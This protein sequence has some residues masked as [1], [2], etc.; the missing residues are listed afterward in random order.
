[1]ISKLQF[2]L[3]FKVGVGISNI[4]Y[5]N[6]KA[7]IS[8][9]QFPQCLSTLNKCLEFQMWQRGDIIIYYGTKFTNVIRIC[10]KISN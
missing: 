5:G 8:I 2:T 7:G 3:I 4:Y 6:H 9:L 10:R 1:M